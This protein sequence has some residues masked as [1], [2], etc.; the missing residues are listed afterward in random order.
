L[1]IFS[2]NFVVPR[3]SA[4]SSLNQFLQP[5][6]TSLW[7]LIAAILTFAV[8]LMTTSYMLGQ[9]FGF[10]QR[11]RPFYGFYESALIIY[12]SLLAQGIRFF[13]FH[14]FW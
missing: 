8:I 1:V 4:S 3:V 11:G 14:S 7:R 10:E 6:S 12:G 13:A 5:F 2:Y 9:K